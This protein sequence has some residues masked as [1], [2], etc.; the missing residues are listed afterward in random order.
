MTANLAP[1]VIQIAIPARLNVIA[2]YPIG[3]LKA[4]GNPEAAKAFSDFVRSSDGQT[5]LAKWGFLPLK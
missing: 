3:T 4:S 1:S 5:I 2:S